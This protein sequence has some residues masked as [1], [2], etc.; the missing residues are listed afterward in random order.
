MLW[1]WRTMPPRIAATSTTIF[2]KCLTLQSCSGPGTRLT[3][4]PLSTRGPGYAYI[5]LRIFLLLR[6]LKNARCNGD[7]SGKNSRSSKSTPGLTR[8][9]KES[10]RFWNRTAIIVFMVELNLIFFF[11]YFY[12][13]RYVSSRNTSS[14]VRVTSMDTCIMSTDTQFLVPPV[15]LPTHHF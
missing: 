14:F 7:K 12:R 2:S 15:F 10:F 8:F 6:R 4:M 5:S 1:Y 11:R 13:L 9:R 3:P